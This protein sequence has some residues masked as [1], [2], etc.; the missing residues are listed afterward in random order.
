MKLRLFEYVILLHEYN[1]SKQLTNTSIVVDVT[2]KLAVDEQT[3]KMYAA[4]QI[5]SELENQL[6]NVEILVRQF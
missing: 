2:L 4:R 5:P 1:E 3:V 6:N